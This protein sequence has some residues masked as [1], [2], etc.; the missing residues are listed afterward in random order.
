MKGERGGGEDVEKAHFGG[1][2]QGPVWDVEVT[3]HE[4]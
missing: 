4:N 1:N 3:D 2:V